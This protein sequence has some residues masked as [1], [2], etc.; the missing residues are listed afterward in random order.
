MLGAVFV[1]AG[2][3]DS[4]VVDVVVGVG[5][6]VVVRAVVV[7]VDVVVAAV[8]VTDVVVVVDVVVAVVGVVVGVAV[9]AVVVVVGEVFVV[10]VVFRECVI[11]EFGFSIEIVC[12]ESMLE[13]SIGS[14]VD[15][16]VI[17]TVVESV[18]G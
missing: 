12:G 5:V 16:F 17:V 10:E 2:V 14:M 11:R 8:V 3:V 6:V 9:R 7:P 1:T 4:V 18:V 15:T 13:F